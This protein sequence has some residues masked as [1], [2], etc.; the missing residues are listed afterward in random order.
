MQIVQGACGGLA[1]MRLEFGESQFDG[2]EIRAVRRQVANANPS[3]RK[4]P[5]DVLDFVG[6]EVVED[7][8]VA[9]VQLGTEHLLKISREHPGIDRA[10]D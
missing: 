3:S 4:Q 9:L 10:F 8:R 7:E 6:G 2:I 1:Q 5:S